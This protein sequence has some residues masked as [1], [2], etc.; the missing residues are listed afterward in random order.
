M[1]KIYQQ[2]VAAL[3]FVSLIGFVTSCDKQR[4]SSINIFNQKIETKSLPQIS[5]HDKRFLEVTGLRKLDYITVNPISMG[6]MSKISKILL[7]TQTA[8]LDSNKKVF[9][10]IYTTRSNSAEISIS[11]SNTHAF[12]IV[13]A[14]KDSLKHSYYE[15]Q[16]DNT[17]RQVLSLPKKLDGPLNMDEIRMLHFAAIKDSVLPKESSIIEFRSEFFKTLK[18]NNSPNKE[19]MKILLM[20]QSRNKGSQTIGLYG[21]ALYSALR[22]DDKPGTGSCGNV[23]SCPPGGNGSCVPDQTAG[24]VCQVGDGGDGG[25]GGCT[26]AQLP[27]LSQT[28]GFS[29]AVPIDFRSI[30]S[31][32]DKFL[33]NSNA[34]K[35]YVSYMYVF[36][37]FAKMD[38]KSLTKYASIIPP[39]QASI[40]TI[41]SDTKNGIVVTTD[42]K[43]LAKEIINTHKDVE[44]KDFQNILSRMEF[45]LNRLTGLKKNDFIREFQGT[46]A[47]VE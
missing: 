37:Q 45:D 31:F 29:L 27:V 19:L 1:K 30:H 41:M 35:E 32:R 17:F 9:L 33:A 15:R 36:S 24:Y 7:P 11:K 20:D 34:G 3:I 21:D 39:L 26:A 5:G 6:V 46:P 8:T 25:G 2:F 40:N 4:Q 12:S 22:A 42:L 28:M 44:D 47:T 38:I 10:Y 16:S 43:Q 13:S 23:V 14:S 18:F